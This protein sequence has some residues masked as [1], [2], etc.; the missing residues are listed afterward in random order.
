MAA[1]KA[2]P[3]APAPAQEMR[4]PSLNIDDLLRDI[5]KDVISQPPSAL[6]SSRKAAGSTGKNSIVIKL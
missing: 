1:P 4:Q 6:K 3:R 5:K 2:A